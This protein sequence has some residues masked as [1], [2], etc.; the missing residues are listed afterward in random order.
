MATKYFLDRLSGKLKPVFE[1]N[2]DAVHG[3]CTP[4]RT[5][6]T[7]YEQPAWRSAE[8]EQPP[9]PCECDGGETESERFD[10]VCQEILTQAGAYSDSSSSA[11]YGSTNELY[12]DGCASL[13]QLAAQ[14][15]LNDCLEV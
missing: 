4:V 11:A 2:C 13:S 15:E 9:A 3:T 14:A 6:A 12:N 8:T 7:S 5:Q 1:E 10:A